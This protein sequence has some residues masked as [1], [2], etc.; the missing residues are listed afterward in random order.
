M[1]SQCEHRSLKLAYLS[2]LRSLVFSEVNNFAVWSDLVDQEVCV[3][4][5]IVSKR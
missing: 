5:S 2:L 3:S 1:Q 4:I